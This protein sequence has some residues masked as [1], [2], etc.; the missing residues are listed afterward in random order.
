MT[1]RL[2]NKV[3]IVFGAGSIG[4]GRD[5]GKAS[6]ALFAANGA[7]VIC[8]YRRHKPPLRWPA[9]SPPGVGTCGRRSLRLT[10]RL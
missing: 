2:Q 9:V 1:D 8:E 6:A 10:N 4:P 7:N 5:N 3:A